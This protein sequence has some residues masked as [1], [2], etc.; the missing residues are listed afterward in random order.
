M[1]AVTNTRMQLDHRRPNQRRLLG[2]IP[3]I[4][5][6]VALSATCGVYLV[7][8]RDTLIK[9]HEAAVAWTAL[10][11]FPIVAGVIWFISKLV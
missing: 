7:Y 10:A 6:I 11:V 3:I 1:G 8:Q 9:S 2:G 5:L 4:V